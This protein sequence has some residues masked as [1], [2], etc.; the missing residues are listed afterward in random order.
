MHK[1]NMI[2]WISNYAKIIFSDNE[3]DFDDICL[4]VKFICNEILR[5]VKITDGR[6]GIFLDRDEWLLISPLAILE[7]GLTYVPIDINISDHKKD[8]IIEDCRFDA[9]ITKSEYLG[10][11]NDIPLIFVDKFC[12][13]NTE[14]INSSFCNEVAYILYTSGTTGIP[15]GVEVYRNSLNNLIEGLSKEISF[16]QND[17]ILCAT[18]I[19]FDIF[20]I[21]SIMALVQGMT[22]ILTNSSGQVNPKVIFNLIQKYKIDIL[23]MTPSH[24]QMLINYD[25]EL[26]NLDCLKS[27]LIG[28]ESF[29]IKMLRILQSKT[30]ALIYNM[31]GPTE[32]TVWSTIANLTTSDT[33]HIGKPIKNTGIYIVDEHDNIVKNNALGE[34]C[35]SGAGL[36]KGYLNK[37]ELTKQSF[38]CLSE[39]SDIN[40][41]KTGD[42]GNFLENGNLAIS[43]RKD[44]QIKIRGHRVELEE[45]EYHLSKISEINQAIVLFIDEILIAVYSSI[46]DVDKK[47][48]IDILCGQ[49]PNYMIPSKFI[50]ITEFPHAPSGKIDRK[51]TAEL[52]HFNKEEKPFDNSVKEKKEFVIILDIIR[53]NS[54][55]TLDSDLTLQTE[56]SDLGLDSISFIKVVVTLEETF[57]FEFDD[58]KLSFNSFETLQN[59]LDYVYYKIN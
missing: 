53:K 47:S 18:N 36:A 59:L 30:S 3:F 38:I 16:Q 49:L 41:Y 40:V 34:I 39:M 51:K 10:K 9:I 46:Q 37:N 21:E 19:T 20:F 42:I 57:G 45:I 56:I 23:Q 55:S 2:N 35:I 48:L 58:E 25:S 31:Y 6:I 52:L 5:N 15:K 29:Q 17:K 14:L 24:M 28:G 22:I 8:I 43:G 13:D 50:Q 44:H 1:T 26:K 11:F 54:K 32:T 4:R 33:I 12:D 27:I 7:V